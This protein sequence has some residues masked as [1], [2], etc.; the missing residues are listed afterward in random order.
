VRHEADY[1]AGGTEITNP[2]LTTVVDDDPR[3]IAR[4]NGRGLSRIGADFDR[5]FAGCYANWTAVYFA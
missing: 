3:T 1:E 4:I 5:R 2:N